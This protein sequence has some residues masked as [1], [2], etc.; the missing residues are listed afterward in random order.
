MD[1]NTLDDMNTI[2]MKKLLGVKSFKSDVL[3]MADGS[4]FRQLLYAVQ[5]I[6]LISIGNETGK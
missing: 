4:V 2:V 5:I 3:S 1:T 6:Y